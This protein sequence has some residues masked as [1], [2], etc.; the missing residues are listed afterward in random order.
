MSE[1]EHDQAAK[2][3]RMAGQI[4]TFY[5]AYPESEAVAGIA[6]HINRFWSR[7]MRE[8]FLSVFPQGDERLEP[9]LRAARGQIRGAAV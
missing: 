4:A 7:R 1:I 8:D 3:L 6:A 5:R 9:L 2:L